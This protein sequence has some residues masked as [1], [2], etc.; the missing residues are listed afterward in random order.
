VEKRRRLELDRVRTP[1]RCLYEKL[2]LLL[3]LLMVMVMLLLLLLML[4]HLEMILL[5]EQRGRMRRR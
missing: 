4:T 5:V 1:L 2:L 3:L